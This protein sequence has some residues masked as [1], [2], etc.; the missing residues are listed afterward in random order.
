MRDLLLTPKD[1]AAPDVASAIKSL[2]KEKFTPEKMQIL[3]RW[4][5]IIFE[6]V[7][8]SEREAQTDF[9]NDIFGK[10]L[11]YDYQYQANEIWN[12]KKEQKTAQDSTRADGVLGFFGQNLHDVRAIIELKS[13]KTPLDIV[14]GGK[15][16]AS[17]VE[18]AFEY[19]SKNGEKCKW[20][21]VSD[22]NEIRLYRYPDKNKA[23]VF[24]IESLLD[25][26]GEEYIHLP[27]F[28]YVFYKGN[29][30]QNLENE[31]DTASWAATER[32]YQKR[33]A[34][35]DK[36]QLDFYNDYTEQRNRIYNDF[37][38]K[39]PDFQPISLLGYAQILLDRLIFMRF[40]TEVGLVESNVLENL[41][42]G[43][44]SCYSHYPHKYWR[45]IKELFA[46]FDIG[47]KR[48]I[49]A[50]NGEL[51]KTIP[52]FEKIQVEDQI[53]A[54]LVY[55]LKRYD[56]KYDLKVEILGNIFEQSIS[57]IE[58]IKSEI[59]ENPEKELQGKRNEDGIFYT[60]QYITE[61]MT[62]EI[63][64]NWLSEK[65]QEI[66]QSL[67]IDFI[68]S[69]ENDLERWKN[70]KPNIELKEVLEIHANY[71][72]EYK[73]RLEKIR[74]L[75]PACG[76]GAFLNEVF[77]QVLRI[78]AKIE[79]N[80]QE[81]LQ[82]LD[83]LLNPKRKKEKKIRKE[84]VQ[85]VLQ[86][87]NRKEGK[88]LALLRKK[89]ALENLYGVDLNFE[90]VEITKLSLYIKIAD[91]QE[92]L[93]DLRPNIRQGDSLISDISISE[94]AFDWEK[95]F[96]HVFEEGGFDII[97]G[98]PPYVVKNKNS[99]YFSQYK[100]HTDLYLMFFERSFNKLLKTKGHLAFITPRFWLVNKNCANFR[101]YMLTKT[102]LRSLT[103]T[104]PFR[105]ANIEC[106]ISILRNRDSETENIKICKDIDQEMTWINTIQKS[107]SLQNETHEILTLLKP[108]DLDLFKKIEKN[109]TLLGEIIQSKR[110][111]E[112]GKNDLRQSVG[113]PTLIGQDV[114]K[115]KISFENT[116]VP[117][118]TKEYLR[119]Q[120][121][122]S[123][124]N[125]IYLRRVANNLIATLGTN[126]AF[127]KNIYGIKV[128]DASPYFILAL[129][130]SKLL[131]YYYKTKF[132]MKKLD[133]FPEI[134]TYL[135]E[136]L[137]IKLV[138]NQE[139]YITLVKEILSKKA[140][141]Q[142]TNFLEKELDLLIYQLY[143]LNETEIQLIE[144][145]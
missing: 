67:D 104:S 69:L 142:E 109:S 131:N 79:Q 50:F 129:I 103:E 105:E 71:W 124:E 83:F 2:F 137:P 113:V 20:V 100:W 92:R 8:F 143:E 97:I 66:L 120:N 48:D 25:K 15:K 93:P 136:A 51:F 91:K 88:R 123:N 116:F 13:Y 5:Q 31:V 121:F 89:I 62:E 60:P 55:F 98:N 72:G 10:V 45:A 110:G 41:I 35:L 135:F 134:Q 47:Y 108:H 33:V 130:N 87:A 43:V 81:I 76:S 12:L 84:S 127:N 122:F 138:E 114:T 61:Y 58:K 11:D 125:M 37:R 44:D 101:E 68:S 75:D 40:T 126:Y 24:K 59:E 3:Q 85:V 94:R 28:F 139:K 95:A 54:D 118:Q 6:E 117:T 19:A 63:L 82:K 30:F 46:S 17:P 65:S 70:Q 106:I 9:L 14:L 22:F 102:D 34:H 49:I 39:N 133:I 132:S 4:Q 115:Y 53:I 111:M 23:L 141:N 107:Y 38:K 74:I 21:I 18:Q 144:N 29:L 90:S 96:P 7:E 56:F 26:K 42:Q 32:A 99:I 16:Q 73:Q 112:I 64:E 119:L 77:E 140:Q 78:Y 36:I 27:I 57:D 52:E 1:F 145:E 128:L 80:Q 86:E